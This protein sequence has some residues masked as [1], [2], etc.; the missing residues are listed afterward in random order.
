LIARV[1]QFKGNSRGKQEKYGM[2]KM[3]SEE[4]WSNDKWS[5]FWR[6]NEKKISGFERRIYIWSGL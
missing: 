6:I 5:Y 3:F 1:D 4:I 2:T